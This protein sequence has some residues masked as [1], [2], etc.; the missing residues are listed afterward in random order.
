MI[1]EKSH[2]DYL[3]EWRK[4][5][6][7]SIRQKERAIWT[8]ISFYSG[9]LLVVTGF[10]EK[11][12]T[13][14]GEQPKA[15]SLLD[16]PLILPV[17]V[18]ITSWGIC[19]ILDANYW[20]RRNLIIIVKIENQFDLK[21]IKP[22][23]KKF[24]APSF[25]YSG[26]YII[27]LVFLFVVFFAFCL[28]YLSSLVPDFNPNLINDKPEEVIFHSLTFI[29]IFASLQYIDFLDS[30]NIRDY[31]ITANQDDEVR[32]K[33]DKDF[34]FKSVIVRFRSIILPMVSIFYIAISQYYQKLYRIPC[35]GD[36]AITLFIL[37]FVVPL[38]FTLLLF[39]SHQFKRQKMW[40]KKT[41]QS[42]LKSLVSV[43][44]F[45][46]LLV[47]LNQFYWNVC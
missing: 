35:T 37:A 34:Y 28:S 30:K 47:I 15:F 43:A 5:L 8:F 21:G 20:L 26:S 41:H 46:A 39:F 1:D 3:I 27:H 13:V 38:L 40:I 33:I 32:K 25:S 14:F 22:A 36:I 19:I 2:G 10:S 31:H 6:W 7:E 29:V 45:M 44:L 17:F 12:I 23:T 42:A 11:L 18:L 4:G 24:N 9:A 16:Y